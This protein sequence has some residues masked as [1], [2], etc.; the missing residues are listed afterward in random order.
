M[1][2]GFVRQTNLLDKA[3]EALDDVAKNI[4]DAL[5]YSM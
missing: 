2:H 3:R 4:R 1:I 5:G